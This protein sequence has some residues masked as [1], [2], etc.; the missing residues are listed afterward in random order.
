M[1]TYAIG[2]I[3]GCCGN[4]DQLLEKIAFDPSG[5]R[6][7]I[8]GDIINRGPTSLP[9]L[10]RVI[11]LGDS[12]ITVLGNHDFHLLSVLCGL[13]KPSP[14]DTIDEILDATDRDELLNWLRHQPLLH[15][16]E[17]LNYTMVHAGLHPAWDLAT[18]S[19]LATDVE[20]AL[21]GENYREFLHSMQ[22]NKPLSWSPSL[23]GTER[24]RFAVNCFTR[25]RY[26]KTSGKLEFDFKGPPQKAPETLLPWYR[27]PQRQNAELRILFGHWASHGESE[28]EN[29][30]PL[31]F[32]CVWGGK[33]RALAL[34]SGEVFEVECQPLA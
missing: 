31:D 34:E 24:L 14:K 1:T 15:H 23:G 10:R 9:A 13:R 32:G 25:L 30:L 29:I 5:D 2:D 17:I 20:A 21:Q 27:V 6:L 22:G 3:Q 8:A 26:C 28:M 7:W 18:A 4:F 19:Q 33:L 12:A 11:E 16:D